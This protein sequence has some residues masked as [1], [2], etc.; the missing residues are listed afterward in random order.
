MEMIAKHQPSMLLSIS[1]Y[2]SSTFRSD[3][4]IQ[5]CQQHPVDSR[6]VA[7]TETVGPSSV[8]IYTQSMPCPVTAPNGATTNRTLVFNFFINCH[9]PKAD[10]FSSAS[11]A[12]K[13]SY[14][15]TITDDSDVFFHFTSDDVTAQT[16]SALVAPLRLNIPAGKGLDV[17]MKPAGF[18]FKGDGVVGV[19]AKDYMRG[20]VDNPSRYH[21]SLVIVDAKT[22]DVVLEH[23]GSIR[24]GM[25]IQRATLVFS[26]YVMYQHRTTLALD[27]SSTSKA[28]LQSA[29]TERFTTQTKALIRSR[30]TLDRVLKD[31][32]ARNTALYSMLDRPVPNRRFETT[33]LP[34]AEPMTFRMVDNEAMVEARDEWQGVMVDGSIPPRPTTGSIMRIPILS[35]PKKAGD[36]SRAAPHKP[37]IQ[38][39]NSWSRS[40]GLII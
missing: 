32:S 38:G 12:T 23:S 25:E 35:L 6:P 26:E 29:I 27:F 4:W 14:T 10:P 11:G 20:V 5:A 8:V 2:D 31:V 28:V 34:R 18:G 40:A 22:D 17:G 9:R 1:Q 37:K 33:I 13:R 16:F 39:S 24:R 36:K 30:T 15:I 7:A 19:V 3:D 21:A